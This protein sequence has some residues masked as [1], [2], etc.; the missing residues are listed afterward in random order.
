MM[1]LRTGGPV[2]SN[3][4][5]LELRCTGLCEGSEA[6]AV[7]STAPLLSWHAF[8]EPSPDWF[9]GVHDFPLCQR[10]EW[11]TSARI[12]LFPCDMG[13]KDG[14]AFVR[15]VQPTVPQAPVTCFHNSNSS[16]WVDKAMCASLAGAGGNPRRSVALHATY[17]HSALSPP[18]ASCVAAPCV[19]LVT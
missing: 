1:I 15:S 8:L 17:Q 9:I 13:T 16:I 3:M 5:A 7:E 6:M 12:P 11:V 14:E 4:P 19:P 18:C 2:L 10:G